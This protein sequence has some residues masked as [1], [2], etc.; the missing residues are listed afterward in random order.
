MLDYD[1]SQ[2]AA[3]VRSERS[4]HKCVIHRTVAQRR[5]SRYIR[6]GSPVYDGGRR[7]LCAL[8]SSY[9]YT[10]SSSIYTPLSFLHP[11]PILISTMR[12]RGVCFAESHKRRNV[13]VGL[14]ERPHHRYIPWPFT[15]RSLRDRVVSL[16]KERVYIACL[17]PP[18][19]L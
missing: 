11:F 17:V 1:I 15:P 19:S 9:Y 18:F 10:P 14:V 3:S 16:L 12:P 7:R 13:L 2:M 8:S 5:L 4:H 6:N